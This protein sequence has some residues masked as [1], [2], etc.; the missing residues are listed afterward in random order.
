VDEWRGEAGV[1]RTA[2]RASGLATALL[3]AACSGG[4]LDPHGPIAS[5]QL[6]IMVNSLVIMLAIVIPTIVATIGFVWWF[7]AS[8]TR[9]RY[10][11]DFVYSGRIEI[12][13]WSIPTLIILFLGGIIWIGSHEL[14]PGQP[15]ASQSQ[16]RPTEVQVVA[17]PWK[18]LFILP[19]YSVATINEL[20]IPAGVPIHLYLTDGGLMN[21][22]W[23][24]QL[25]GMI[26]TMNGMTT[27][28]HLQADHPGTFA[29]RSGMYSG[30]GFSDMTFVVRALPQADFDRWIDDAKKAPG[31]LDRAT[32]TELAKPG[33][34]RSPRTFNSVDSGLFASITDQTIPPSPGPAN[35]PATSQGAGPT[36]TR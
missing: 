2:R 27:Q 22:F 3:L 11:P 26:Y 34:V 23:V 13:V 35:P 33:T 20:V 31:P 32:Y 4:P 9:A 36:A 21:T 30:D 5:A 17:L 8:N 14:D 1:S 25:A 15:I 16:I 6:K 7:R 18:W 29:G 10:R 28:L 12:V 19:G 24:P